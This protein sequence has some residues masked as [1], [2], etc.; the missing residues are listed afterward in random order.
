MPDPAP[1]RPAKEEGA[2]SAPTRVLLV[3]DHAIVREGLRAVL[4]Q[5][6]SLQIVGEAADGT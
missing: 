6:D 4:S 5:S 2:V 1:E 3:D